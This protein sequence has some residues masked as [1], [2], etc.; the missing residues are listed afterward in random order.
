MRQFGDLVVWIALILV[1][2]GVVYFTPKVAQ[3]V[4]AENRPAEKSWLDRHLAF[5]PV[6][7]ADDPR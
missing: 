6:L 4:S 1:L 3:Y 7:S 2:A 5:N